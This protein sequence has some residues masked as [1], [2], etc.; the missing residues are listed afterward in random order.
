MATNVAELRLGDLFVR[1]GL[2]DADQLKA[3][4][5]DSKEGGTRIGFS[6]VKLG[7]VGENEL[8]RMPSKPDRLQA[9]DPVQ[10]RLPADHRSGEGRKV[11]QREGEG[12][13][14]GTALPY[15]SKTFSGFQREADTV[16]GLYVTG[17]CL[18]VGMEVSD[19]Q[20]RGHSSP[21]SQVSG[22]WV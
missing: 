7:F 16:H 13:F 18:E 6:L 1:E 9:V 2:I 5:A 8:T 20:Q 15:Y 17:F 19:F 12:A 22:W 11:H 3:A 14:T 21:S 4:L 10:Q